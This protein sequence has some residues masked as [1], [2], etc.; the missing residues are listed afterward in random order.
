MK[1]KKKKDLLLFSTPE[2]NHVATYII[3]IECRKKE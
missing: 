2:F 3:T 1:F